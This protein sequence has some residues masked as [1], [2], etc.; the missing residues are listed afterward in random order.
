M[1]D[2]VSESLGMDFDPRALNSLIHSGGKKKLDTLLDMF[3]KEGPARVAEIEKAPDIQ[4]AKK[5]AVALK[6]SAAH[7]GLLSL[8]DLCDQ[9]LAGKDL[10]SLKGQFK[11][12][13]SKALGYLEQTRKTL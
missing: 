13:L 2:P 10:A 12:A 9:I 1:G 7:L 11:P 6:A 5:S 4:D 3:K 8:E